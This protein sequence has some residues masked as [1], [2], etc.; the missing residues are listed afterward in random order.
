MFI[1][2]NIDLLVR[3][4]SLVEY[5][6]FVMSVGMQDFLPD[7]V[8]ASRWYSVYGLYPRY[9]S[10]VTAMQKAKDWVQCARVSNTVSVGL[11][12]YFYQ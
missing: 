3:P 2:P 7:F 12:L 1:C 8:R 4:K 10:L 5:I 9:R 6:T 11:F